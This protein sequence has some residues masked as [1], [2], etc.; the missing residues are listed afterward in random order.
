MLYST[1]TY[2][3]NHFEAGSNPGLQKT[4]RQFDSEIIIDWCNHL[5]EKVN[6]EGLYYQIDEMVLSEKQIY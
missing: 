6:V 1:I 4:K 5:I 2:E 3:D